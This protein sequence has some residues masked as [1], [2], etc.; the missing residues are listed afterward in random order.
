MHQNGRLKK[1][2]KIILYTILVLISLS[3][4][5]E[6]HVENAINL[7]SKGLINEA[8]NELDLALNINPN[9]IN[10]LIN[11]GSYLFEINKFQDSKKCFLE[12][13][14]IDPD[15]TLAHYNCGLTTNQLQQFQESISHFERAI[16]TKGG[17]ILYTE[18]E[19][20]NIYE[21]PMED[22]I[23]ERGLARFEMDSLSLSF[24]DF[25]FCINKRYE[26]DKSYYNRG[27]IYFNYN[28]IEEGCN[29]MKKSFK[30]HNSFAK[31]MLKENCW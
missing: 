10:A 15:N 31:E 13:I 12:A 1:Y 8:I 4:N 18:N 14:I 20:D 29:D 16:I 28:M 27:L 21:V 17:E 3:C 6:K 22:I 30:L 11:K 26:L 24:E 9:N 19:I 25:S 7:H 23:F 5:G 2:M